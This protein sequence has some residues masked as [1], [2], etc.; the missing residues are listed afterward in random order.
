[1]KW[2]HLI[3]YLLM[4]R[5]TLKEPPI[6]NSLAFA[7]AKTEKNSELENLIQGS[8][9]VDLQRVGD[10]LFDNQLYEAARIL[11]VALK[12]NAKIASCLVRLK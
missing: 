10:R 1:M 8:N 9:S 2:D 3:K 5:S 7:Y 11:F 4:C 12:N 6:D